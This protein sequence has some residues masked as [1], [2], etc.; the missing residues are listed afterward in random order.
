[1]TDAITSSVQQFQNGQLSRR[2]VVTGLAASFAAATGSAAQSPSP[3]V[4]VRR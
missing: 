2:E 1:M 3:P 4:V